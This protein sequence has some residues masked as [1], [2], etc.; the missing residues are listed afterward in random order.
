MLEQRA[1]DIADHKRFSGPKNLKPED[2]YN[3]LR[4]TADD[5]RLRALDTRDPTA[6]E[7][8]PNSR[9]FDFDSGFGFV[10]AQAALKAIAGH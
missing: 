9:G 3:V 2:I 4:A 6:T 7:R 8:I 5:I 1:N 10:N